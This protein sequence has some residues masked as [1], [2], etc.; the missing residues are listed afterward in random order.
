[1]IRNTFEVTELF[2]LLEGRFSSCFRIYNRDE[3][4][5]YKIEMH[6]VLEI[7]SG[8]LNNADMVKFAKFI[9]MN[10]INEEMMKQAYEIV[11][12]TIPKPQPEPVVTEEVNNV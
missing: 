7:T 10:D 5:T 11:N 6:R 12:T 9:P 1:M 8:F 4:E 2:A 3:F